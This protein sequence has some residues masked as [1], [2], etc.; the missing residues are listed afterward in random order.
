MLRV[1]NEDK[2]EEF[3]N[4]NI[5]LVRRVDNED[6]LEQFNYIIVMLSVDMMISM[7]KVKEK[8]MHPLIHN[9]PSV[10]SADR[11]KSKTDMS[12]F[13]HLRVPS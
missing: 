12:M 8:I 13:I 7:L 2:L 10:L 3:Y 9:V 6:K 11:I 1:D 5:T 4:I